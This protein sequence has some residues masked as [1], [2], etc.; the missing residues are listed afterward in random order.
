MRWRSGDKGARGALLA[1]GLQLGDRLCED[2]DLVRERRQ[3]DR[4]RLL[5]GAL[6]AWVVRQLAEAPL[7]AYESDLELQVVPAESRRGT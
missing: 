6:L 1:G 2:L 7:G 3:G 5:K 4:A